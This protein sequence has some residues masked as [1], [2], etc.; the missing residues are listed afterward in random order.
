MHPNV[1]A[2]LF[3]A[4]KTWKQPKYPPTEEWI[5]MWY[6]N[7]MENYLAIKEQNNTI[8]SNIYGPRDYHTKWSKSKKDKYHMISL[9][10][11]DTKQLIYKTENELKTSKSN[12]CL[13][14]G[15]CGGEG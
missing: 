1:H 10:H 4:A 14:K 5:K 3:T 11:K 8:C 9:I 6:L 15:I 2:A 7:T 12:L 13:P